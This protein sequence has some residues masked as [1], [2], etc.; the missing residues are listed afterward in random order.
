MNFDVE[1]LLSIC[2]PRTE[3]RDAFVGRFFEYALVR[4]GQVWSNEKNS[5]TRMIANL[6]SRGG[7]DG[8]HEVL[9]EAFCRAAANTVASYVPDCLSQAK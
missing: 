9:L 7:G 4:L 2:N 6:V 1:A 3:S 5:V 8:G